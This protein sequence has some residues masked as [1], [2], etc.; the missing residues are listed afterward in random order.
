MMLPAE[1]LSGEFFLALAPGLCFVHV[2][3]FEFQNRARSAPFWDHKHSSAERQSS[4]SIGEENDIQSKPSR[5]LLFSC[6][7]RLYLWDTMLLPPSL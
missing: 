2:D 4:E 5:R 7:P 6:L 3:Q 1:M